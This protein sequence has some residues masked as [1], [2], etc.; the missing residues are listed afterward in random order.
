MAV[1]M[2]P[3]KLADLARALGS[4]LGA[5][6]VA[7]VC[8]RSGDAADAA[9]VHMPEFSRRDRAAMVD[10]LRTL[11]S[12]IEASG[13]AAARALADARTCPHARIV[14]TILS[15]SLLCT[16]C[17]ALIDPASPAARSATVVRIPTRG[18]LWREKPAALAGV[19]F[20][21]GVVQVGQPEWTVVDVRSDSVGTFNVVVERPP[22]GDELEPTQRGPIDGDR[23]V[24]D[25]ERV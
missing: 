19:R 22:A 17:N 8:I 4:T 3:M 20:G 24:E 23:F 12:E 21:A 18:E 16:A 6:G 2:K 10:A 9:Y 25:W 11:A 15:R 14:E 5:D 13:G 7:L 1:P